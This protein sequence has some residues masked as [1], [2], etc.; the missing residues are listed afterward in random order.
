MPSDA[1]SGGVIPIPSASSK[2]SLY[3]LGNTIKFLENCFNALM[4]IIRT[5]LLF[6]K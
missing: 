4:K 5:E 2:K 6:I 3:S 1:S